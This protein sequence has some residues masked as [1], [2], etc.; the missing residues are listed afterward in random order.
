MGVGWG[1]I[2]RGMATPN[3]YGESCQ[4]A[5]GTGRLPEAI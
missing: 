5:I 2:S 3:R 1:K 4:T